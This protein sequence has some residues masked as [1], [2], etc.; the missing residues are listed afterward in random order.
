MSYTPIPPNSEMVIGWAGWKDSERASVLISLIENRKRSGDIANDSVTPLLA[1]LRELLPWLWQWH[2]EPELPFW[3][4]SPAE[5]VRTYLENKQ[6][7]HGLLD[8][9]LTTWR[10]PKP[11][12]GRPRKT[13]VDPSR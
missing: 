4:D 2:G 12:R 8:S 10:A 3:P 13:P 9:D 7:K 1:G 6:S 11:K 5:E